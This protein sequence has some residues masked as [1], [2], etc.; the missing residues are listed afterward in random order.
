MHWS[1]RKP[2]A[3]AYLR[4]QQMTNRMTART[5]NAWDN[6]T[7]GN[8]Y[9]FSIWYKDF[10]SRWQDAL[11]AQIRAIMMREGWSAASGVIALVIILITTAAIAIQDAG[12]LALLIGL[13]AT[14]PRQIEMTL[15]MHQLTAG[16]TDLMAIWA[17]IKGVCEH[18][19]LAPD[20]G[21]GDRID[22]EQ[23]ELRIDGCV[24]NCTTLAD[25]LRLV[26]AQPH[27]R[28]SIRGANGAGKSS[29]LM[30]LKGALR[31][32]AY[33][34]PSHDRLNFCVNTQTDLSKESAVV[35]VG[36]EDEEGPDAEELNATEIAQEKAGYSSGERQ[37]QVLREISE[38]T[39]F[40]VYLL[41][42][43]DANLDAE[44][45]CRADAVVELLAQRA[46]VIEISHHDRFKFDVPADS[47]MQ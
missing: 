20:T 43:W 16:L 13:A 31:G 8:H 40:A 44:N 42:E 22:Y 19:K 4:N 33:Y 6:V 15:D 34:W 25:V 41:D 1:I 27:G 9:N 45:R 38:R 30:A 47:A 29:L 26:L 35:D 46:R 28:V 32:R 39:D 12:N 37:L 14:L 10:R 5:Y 17:R 3:A 21:F 23:I 7:T 18:I 11:S 2:I 24:Q 36:L